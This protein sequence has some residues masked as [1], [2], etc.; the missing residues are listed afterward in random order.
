MLT[1]RK[2]P[3]KY[4][5]EKHIGKKISILFKT[6]TLFYYKGRGDQIRLL[7]Y[8]YIFCD[9]SITLTVLVAKIYAITK[10]SKL[11]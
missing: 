6:I 5:K 4:K 3:W 2:M 1:L 11:R 10:C 7:L 8:V 9:N